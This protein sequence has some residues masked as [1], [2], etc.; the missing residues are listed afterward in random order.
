MD[1]I[2]VSV[3]KVYWLGGR[4]PKGSDIIAA[5][6]QLCHPVELYKQEYSREGHDY[7]MVGRRGSRPAR[8][9]VVFAMLDGKKCYIL[10]PRLSYGYIY[11]ESTNWST[12]GLSTD[13]DHQDIIRETKQFAADL[14]ALLLK[15]EELR[16][17]AESAE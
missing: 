17:L 6:E 3:E 11:A 12:G 10:S 15:N 7:Y 4:S 13:R 16:K 14:S 2:P 9:V 1:D 5:V 8:N